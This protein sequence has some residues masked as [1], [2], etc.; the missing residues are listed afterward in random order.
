[1]TAVDAMEGSR[2]PFDPV[3]LKPPQ[4]RLLVLRRSAL[5]VQTDELQRVLER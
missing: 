2:L 4:R 1:L 3:T 5:G